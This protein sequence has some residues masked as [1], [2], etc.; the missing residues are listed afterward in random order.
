MR[1]TNRRIVEFTFTRRVKAD[2]VKYV[3]TRRRRHQSCLLW[4]TSTPRARYITLHRYQP[5]AQVLPRD[6]LMTDKM[7]EVHGEGRD[8]LLYTSPSPRDS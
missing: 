6:L 2:V 8:C 5:P 4:R 3:S 7:V 1:Y